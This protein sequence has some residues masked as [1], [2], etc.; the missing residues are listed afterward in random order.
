[1]VAHVVEQDSIE[2]IL[3][4]VQAVARTTRGERIDE[5]EF[6]IS[7]PTFSTPHAQTDRII[8]EIAQW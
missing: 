2:D 6:G 4:C 5:P 1:M 3:S 7:D 8:A